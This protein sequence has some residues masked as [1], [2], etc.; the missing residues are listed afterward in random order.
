MQVD[1]TQLGQALSQNGGQLSLE[2]RDGSGRL[3]ASA[4]LELHGPPAAES[5]EG[6]I[7][8]PDRSDQPAEEPPGP[9]FLSIL[10]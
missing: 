5:F 8:T 1:L 7:V 10:A 2:L 9:N 4:S 3:I 6:E